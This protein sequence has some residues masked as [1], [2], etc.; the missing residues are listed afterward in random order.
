[1]DESGKIKFTNS[2]AKAIENLTAKTTEL[3]RVTKQLVEAQ[4]NLNTIVRETGSSNE[5]AIKL[6][7]ELI[8][9]YKDSLVALDSQIKKVKK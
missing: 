8:Q 2:H 5:A 4:E 6:Q 9:S 1:M 3:E 7:K